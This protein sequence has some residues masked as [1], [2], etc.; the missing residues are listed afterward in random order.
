MLKILSLILILISAE[1]DVLALKKCQTLDNYTIHGLWPEYSPTKWPQFCNT[2]WDYN[3]SILT[4]ILN[5]MNLYWYS[6]EVK[7]NNKFSVNNYLFWH[8]EWKKHGTC[9]LKQPLDYFNETL[10]LYYDYYKKVNYYCNENSLQ[11]LIKLV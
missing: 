4:P 8:H 1:Y 3:P 9:Q 2:S 11:C 6:C 5:E 10:Q 7:N